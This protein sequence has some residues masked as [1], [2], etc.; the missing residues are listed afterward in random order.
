MRRPAAI[1]LLAVSLAALPAG[2]GAAPSA[3]ISIGAIQ[4][5]FVPAQRET[6]YSVSRFHL[7]GKPEAVTVSWSLHLELVDKAGAPEPGTAGT[8]AAVDLGCT[9]AGVGIPEPQKTVSEPGQ[10]TA[11]FVWHHPD[12][13]DSV[14]K[15]RYHCDHGDMGP[16]GHQGLVTVVVADKEWRCTATYKGSNT[17]TA[18][19]DKDGTASVPKCSAVR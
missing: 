11:G 18:Q 16:H 6:V 19:S 15:G 12:A 8:G 10:P 3:S 5:T 1:A 2:A 14:P 9:N 17:S 4:A 7:N 13:A